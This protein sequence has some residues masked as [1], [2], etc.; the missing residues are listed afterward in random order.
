[1]NHGIAVTSIVREDLKVVSPATH[2]GRKKMASEEIPFQPTIPL[3]MLEKLAV[4]GGYAARHAMDYTEQK[5][6][7]D[8]VYVAALKAAKYVAWDAFERAIAAVLEDPPN[9]DDILVGLAQ[10][11]RMHLLHVPVWDSEG[12]VP[13]LNE[14][15]VLIFLVRKY[16]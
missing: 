15:E 12:L 11:A 16:A 13:N 5:M 6:S 2:K 3:H 14:S 9:L 1:M 7:S 10:Q 4:I 8:T